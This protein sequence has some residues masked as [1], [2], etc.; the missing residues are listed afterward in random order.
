VSEFSRRKG[1]L[2]YQGTV[3]YFSITR[4]SQCGKEST[5]I[6]IIAVCFITITFCFISG[7]Y[8]L[9]WKTWIF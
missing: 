7:I 8:K 4:L 3:I 2:P 6:K 9:L 1:H 5:S